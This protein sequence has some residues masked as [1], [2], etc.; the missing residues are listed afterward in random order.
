MRPRLLLHPFRQASGLALATQLPSCWA[1]DA[2]GTHEEENTSEVLR[3][4][5]RNYF[6]EHVAHC[7]ASHRSSL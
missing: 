6:A 1:N 2:S 7:A 5:Q 4:L 3:A